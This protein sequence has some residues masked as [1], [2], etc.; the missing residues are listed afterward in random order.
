MSATVPGL[1]G[2]DYSQLAVKKP[3]LGMLPVCYTASALSG[4]ES[5]QYRLVV[6]PIYV[7]SEAGS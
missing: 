2:L 4:L 5:G 1:V 6:K 3:P 7:E